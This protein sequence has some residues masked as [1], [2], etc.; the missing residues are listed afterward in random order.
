MAKYCETEE[1]LD[2]L[3]PKFKFKESLT[4]TMLKK[5]QELPPEIRKRVLD[6]GWTVN[7]K[8]MD[9]IIF[10]TNPQRLESMKGRRG[11]E[12][13]EGIADDPFYQAFLEKMVGSRRHKET[14]NAEQ[15]RAATIGVKER[16]EAL[17]RSGS[18]IADAI[19]GGDDEMM[20]YFAKTINEA[21]ALQ[22]QIA[23]AK[24][25]V[26]RS[27]GYVRELNKLE[28]SSK[29]LLSLFNALEC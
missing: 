16:Y 21:Q 8:D 23:G 17:A 28:K 25:E 24:S 29:N 6:N 11:F 9:E 13:I 27:L 10:G 14:M 20:T 18:T 22:F 15:L 19:E 12:Q 26:G 2:V 3:F 5:M 1:L 4:P 7:L